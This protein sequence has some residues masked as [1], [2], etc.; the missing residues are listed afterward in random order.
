MFD[1]CKDYA[2]SSLN[3]KDYNNTHVPFV[4]LILIVVHSWLLYK[5]EEQPKY[6]EYKGIF[7]IL[8][9]KFTI[10]VPYVW[11]LWESCLIRA[12]G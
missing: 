2:F 5:P 7:L 1:V 11:Q 9:C 12:L 3:K 10:C 4:L 6:F 8:N